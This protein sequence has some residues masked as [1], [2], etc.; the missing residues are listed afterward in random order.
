MCP[1]A[2]GPL[3]GHTA[4][5]D[6]LLVSPTH[7]RSLCE[8]LTALLAP[9]DGNRT[10]TCLA[11]T[12]PV[13]GSEDADAQRL[14]FFLSKS[15]WNDVKVNNRRLQLIAP[16]RPQPRTISVCWS[17]TTLGTAR[18]APPPGA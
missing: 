1:P 2:P 15:T 4:R 18:T 14:Q 16:T 8:Y 12:A 5:F 11:S 13:T 17:S 10:L 6:D 7:W 3:E 9:R